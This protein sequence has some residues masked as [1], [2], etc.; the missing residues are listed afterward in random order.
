MVISGT[1]SHFYSELIL[2]FD[3][4]W[5]R[6]KGLLASLPNPE[7]AFSPPSIPIKPPKRGP[8]IGGEGGI[9][10]LVGLAPPTDF[11][12]APLWPLRYLS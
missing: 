7:R 2:L 8:L 10:T 11:E 9:R 5:L 4:N 12:S 3:L 1:K 6:D